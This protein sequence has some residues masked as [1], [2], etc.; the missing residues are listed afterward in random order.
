M[1]NSR[2]LRR[3]SNEEDPPTLLAAQFALSHVCWLIAYSLAGQL[4]ATAGL[5][6]VLLVHAGLTLKSV[7]LAAQLWPTPKF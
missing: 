7:G 6:V 2:V 1:K 5:P 4:G 3:S